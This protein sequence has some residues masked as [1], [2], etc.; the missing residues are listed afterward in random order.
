MN[1][2]RYNDPG[3]H[4]P[5]DAAEAVPR[6]PDHRIRRAGLLLGFA[7]GGFFDGIL[8]HQIL[9]W[10]HLLSAIQTESWA[11]CVSRSRWTGCSMPSCTS[12]RLPAYGPCIARAALP[13]RPPCEHQVRTLDGVR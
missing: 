5:P 6:T 1:P 4:P 13:P 11:T 8:L 7:M 12:S 9:Q 2:L 3:P 10:H